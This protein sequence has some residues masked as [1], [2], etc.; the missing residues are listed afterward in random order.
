M[1]FL[2]FNN[3]A[4]VSIKVSRNF[5]NQ[6]L[7]AILS[8]LL[9][10]IIYLMLFAVAIGIFIACGYIAFLLVTT[11]AS[12]ATLALGIG[13]VA[14][15]VF[16][17]YFMM[18]F[19]FTGNKSDYSHLTEISIEDEPE[20]L[21][22]IQELV[23]EVG[24]KF[25]KRIYVS[26][27][28][29]ASVFYDS[30][31]WSMLLPIRK[32]LHIGLGLVNTTTVNELKGIVAHEFGHFSQ[33]SMKVGSFV[34]NV[35]KII[36]N[37][38]YDNDDYDQAM[39][40]WASKSGYFVIMIWLATYYN[41][42]V[43][44]ILKFVYKIVNINYLGLSR[45]MEFHADAIAASIVG[46][47]PMISAMLRLDLCSQSYD[48]VINYYNEN[49]DNAV[50][51][52]NLF[53]QQLFAMKFIA[54][55]NK[56]SLINNLPNI[57]EEYSERFNKSKLVIKNQWDSHPSMEDRI[58]EFKRLNVVEKKLD[59]RPANMLFRDIEAVQQKVSAKIFT[60]IPYTKKTVVQDLQ[61]FSDDLQ[62]KYAESKYPELFNSYYDNYNVTPFDFETF[63]DYKILPEA[64][65]FS[66]ETTELIYSMNAQ[67]ADS[68]TLKSIAE[69]PYDLKTFDYD[70]Q[71]Y[72]VSEAA[73]VSKK[74]ADEVEK[75]KKILSKNDLNIYHSFLKKSEIQKSEEQ[76]KILYRD[77]FKA[78]KIWE[79]QIGLYTDIIEK[80]SFAYETTPFEQISLKLKT[81]YATEKEFK[82]E[83]SNMLNDSF[84]KDAITETLQKDCSHYINNDFIYFS[85]NAYIETE[86]NS[87]NAAVSHYLY[88]LQQNYYLKKKQL[89]QFKASL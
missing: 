19:M 61:P 11:K 70:G 41:K 75:N 86:I 44:F 71:K 77:Y 27:E 25:P 51:T 37:I 23:S 74:V 88:L 38:L 65:L 1:L 28:V 73:L 68:T 13:L 54:E 85:E 84:F 26:P 82:K 81:F 16:V 79:K 64:V 4:M 55:T 43:Q 14:V 18:K 5:K 46:S 20:L 78:D 40:N 57:T 7:R 59:N 17:L 33:K 60:N 24:T 10:V 42:V 47:Q 29:N 72:K 21:Q 32:N 12:F 69:N 50:T 49:F 83:L 22:L 63:S 15:G 58:S 48:T 39:H 9:F 87:K 30:S 45:E 34:Y 89:L 56:I 31:F 6:A 35:N 66:A 80:F 3:N 36:H 76:Y 52:D 53:P 8:I 62:K 2:N 67:L